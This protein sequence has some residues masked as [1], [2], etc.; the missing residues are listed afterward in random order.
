[1]IG[2]YLYEKYFKLL[3]GLCKVNEIEAITT[4]M[5]R[6][7]MSLLLVLAGLCPPSGTS[8]DWNKWL[9]WQPIPYNYV[10]FA[11]DKV[12]QRPLYI[13]NIIHI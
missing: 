1:M 9:N 2:E 7:K 13:L 3:Q 4:D 6:T 8:F 11:Q 12:L 5:S 10:P